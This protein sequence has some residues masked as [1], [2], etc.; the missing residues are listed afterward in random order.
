MVSKAIKQL[1]KL[2]SLILC[3]ILPAQSKE[4]VV[5][6]ELWYPYQFHNNESKLTGVDVEIFNLI[7]KKADMTISYVEL[8]WQRHLMYIQNG[9]VD[10][11]FGAS[12]T[13]ERAKTAHFSLGYRKEK[14]NLF[15]KKKLINI[16]VGRWQRY[17]R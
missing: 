8:P 11:A 6:W 4:F 16:L 7:A 10:I 5:G 9:M 14:V 15:V 17:A 2:F 1:I 12:H 13:E 3:F